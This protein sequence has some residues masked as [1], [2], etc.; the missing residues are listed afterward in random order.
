MT[1]CNTRGRDLAG[2][3][4]VDH[5][6]VLTDDFAGLRIDNIFSQQAAIETAAHRLTSNIVAPADLGAV[7]RA[8][9]IF[10]DDDILRNVHKTARQITGIRCTKSGIR[11]TFARAVS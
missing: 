9:V 2:Q 4:L 11:Q 10:V 1:S 8:A 6:V 3:I 5:I 7:V